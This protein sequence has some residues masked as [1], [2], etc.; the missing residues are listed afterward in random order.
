VPAET[1]ADRIKRLQAKADLTNEEV[2]RAAGLTPGVYKAIKGGDIKTLKLRE[3]LRL[4]K[5]L[6]TTPWALIGEPDPPD[7]SRRLRAKIEKARRDL[8]E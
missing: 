7:E 5:A 3:G 4:A 1:L 8:E 6:G 2:A